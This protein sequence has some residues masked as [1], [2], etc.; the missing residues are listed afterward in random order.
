M[1]ITGR[2]T[3]TV[4]P[5]LIR[6]QCKQDNFFSKWKVWFC[7]NCTLSAITNALVGREV[8]AKPDQEP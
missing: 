8:N 3:R 1:R 2:L 7:T 4:G 6:L 5:V